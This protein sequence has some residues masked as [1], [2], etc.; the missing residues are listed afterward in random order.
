MTIVDRLLGRER[1][2]KQVDA[3]QVEQARAAALLDF[4]KKSG[5]PINMRPVALAQSP[6]APDTSIGKR[7]AAYATNALVFACVAR[8]AESVTDAHLIIERRNGKGLYEPVPVHPALDLMYKPN[9]EMTGDEMLIAMSASLD[10]FG[11]FI[12]EIVPAPGGM[13][14]ELWPLDPT[15]LKPVTE[16]QKDG[17][18]E[19]LGYEFRDGSY[20]KTIPIENILE[21]TEWDLG[22]NGSRLSRAMGSVESDDAQSRYVRAFFANGGVPGGVVKINDRRL[23]PEK[24]DEIRANWRA[25]YSDKWGNTHDVAV[26]D[27]N[28][29]YQRV[30]AMLNELGSD[31]LRGVDE[32]RICLTFDVPPLIVYSYIGLT[33]ATYSNLDEAWS[34]FWKTTM[35]ALLKRLRNWLTFHLLARY[36]DEKAINTRAIRF[37]F[38]ISEV[39]ALVDEN[40]PLYRSLR[41][42]F[43]SGLMT[44]DETREK[45]GW[46]KYPDEFLG[47]LNFYQLQ[48]ANKLDIA[49][50]DDG[51][52]PVEDAIDGNE[53]LDGEDMGDGESDGEDAGAD[54]GT[55]D[56]DKR[57][58]ARPSSKALARAAQIKQAREDEEQLLEE[59]RQA[60]YAM[61]DEARKAESV[62]ADSFVEELGNLAAVTMLGVF[63]TAALLATI[64]A[65][66][67]EALDRVN[68]HISY[69]RLSAGELLKDILAGRYGGVHGDG[70]ADL[71]A[72]AELWQGSAAHVAEIGRVFREDDPVLQWSFDPAKEHCDDCAAFDGIRMKA[73]RWRDIWPVDLLPKGHGLGCRGYR[74]GCTLIES[75]GAENYDG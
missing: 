17:S 12:A 30:G 55:G 22:L 51:Q 29:D 39:P 4:H 50:V 57:R 23:T 32:S 46:D 36:E 5:F 10:V 28:A 44:V 9:P 1:L 16:K 58:R 21:F 33:R 35:S 8:R 18:V 20:R 68:V 13:P 6:G 67:Q 43:R 25:K 2:Q 26:L 75:D 47:G 31:I 19:L 65:I 24:A 15:K 72:R 62:D 27:M 66:T 49:E 48:A 14:A 52:N 63:A 60:V 64:E 37:A 34:Q 61:A 53:P 3:L 42:I 7:Q 69:A 70:E 38:D 54:A 11:K 45:M 56:G 71:M 73:T 74:C 40:E 59:Y 41:L